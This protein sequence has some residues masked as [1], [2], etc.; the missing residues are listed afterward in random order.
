MSKL[1]ACTVLN[2]YGN[3]WQISAPPCFGSVTDYGLF[4]ACIYHINV[5][6]ILMK[7]HYTFN[8]DNCTGNK[9]LNYALVSSSEPDIPTDNTGGNYNSDSYSFVFMSLVI[10][11]IFF[12]VG[13][14][15]SK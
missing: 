8:G 13:V 12:L 1:P 4:D 3:S 9:T 5:D 11:A 6:N 2:G 15:V 7:Y 14:K 10:L